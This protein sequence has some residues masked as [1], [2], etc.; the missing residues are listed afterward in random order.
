[1]RSG[2]AVIVLFALEACSPVS[3]AGDAGDGGASSNGGTVSMKTASFNGTV[4]QGSF[5]F[6]MENT[7]SL[8]VATMTEVRIATGSGEI[9]FPTA[10]TRCKESD[11]WCV[12]HGTT[13][14]GARIDVVNL[15]TTGS[16]AISL[17]CNGSALRS[18]ATTDS[19]AAATS[20]VPTSLTM[21]GTFSDGSK[22]TASANVN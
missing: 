16:A 8:D 14:T 7:N 18:G 13:K 3:A 4:S 20:D 19:P 2:F 11:V 6:V 9:V 21:K 15:S 5:S 17:L 12:G 22:W 10:C 1:M